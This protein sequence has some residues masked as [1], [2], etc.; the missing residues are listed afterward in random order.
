MYLVMNTVQ[1]NKP[2]KIKV[3]RVGDTYVN[4]ALGV[5]A[6]RKKYARKIEVC[7]KGLGWFNLDTARIER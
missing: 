7:Y 1:G 5:V 3:T 6:R 2:Y 4:H